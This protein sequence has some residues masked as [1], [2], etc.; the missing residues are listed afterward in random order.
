ML[1]CKYFK[2]DENNSCMN[3]VSIKSQKYEKNWPC[4]NFFLDL[5][6][7]FVLLRLEGYESLKNLVVEFSA[8]GGLMFGVHDRALTECV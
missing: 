4:G 1:F 8:N 5:E 6:R 2:F 7:F 3:Q